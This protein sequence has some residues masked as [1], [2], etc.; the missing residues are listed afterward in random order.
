MV[1]RGIPLKKTVV[2][3]YFLTALYAFIGVVLALT[4]SIRTIYAVF[5][6]AAV[7][8]VSAVIIWKKGYLKMEGLRG[9]IRA[10]P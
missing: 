6:Y 1:D 5:V 4:T 10:K 7:F 9:A 2:L 3:C 8:L